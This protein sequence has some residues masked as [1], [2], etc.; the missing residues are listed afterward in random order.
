MPSFS[1]PWWKEHGHQASERS[2]RWLHAVNR[3]L[4]HAYKSLMIAYIDIP[5]PPAIADSEGG[6]VSILE[7]YRV[8][9][10]MV[11]RWSGNRNRG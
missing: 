9:E 7:Q 1:D 10:V 2:W 8:R 11:R 6:I 3:V 5:P 4:A